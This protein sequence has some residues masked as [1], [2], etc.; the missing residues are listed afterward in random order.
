MGSGRGK[1]WVYAAS[2][3]G[4][5]LIKIGYSEVRDI[6]NRMQGLRSQFKATFVLVGAVWISYAVRRVEMALHKKLAAQHIERE[7]FYLPMNPVV[8][9]EL[10]E[11]VLPDVRKYLAEQE[12]L[13]LRDELRWN[14]SERA[15]L[16]AQVR[17]RKEM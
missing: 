7:W 11:A 3:V 10:V 12:T 14:K 6:E 17:Q 9:R 15:R 8:F 13:Y 2:E 1:G 4:T 5:P 16:L